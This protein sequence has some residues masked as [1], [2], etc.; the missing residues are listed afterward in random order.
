MASTRR[1]IDL[2]LEV[3]GKPAATARTHGAPQQRREPPSAESVQPLEQ[4]ED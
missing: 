4:S 1:R 2:T 3:L